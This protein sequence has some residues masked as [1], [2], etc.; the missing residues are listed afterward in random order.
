MKEQILPALPIV[1]KLR[2]KSFDGKSLCSIDVVNKGRS[3]S[4]L[5]PFFQE[6]FDKFY[7]YLSGKTTSLDIPLDF[8]HLTDFQKRVLKEMKKI[9]YGQVHSYKQIAIGMKSK[10]Y[11]AI[12]SA[13]G[14][15]PF[16]LIYPCHRVIGSDN[17]G[18]FAH[19]PEMKQKLLKLEGAELSFNS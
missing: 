12:G 7:A 16:M 13:C 15:N 1:G 9:P 10:G 17:L 3:S 2:L 8:S 14:K 18:G 19:G 11:Q 6:C 4:Q 5:E